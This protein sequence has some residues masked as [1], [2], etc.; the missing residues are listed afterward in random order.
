MKLND[1]MLWWETPDGESHE[2]IIDYV[3][4]L[5]SDQNYQHDLNLQNFRLYNDEEVTSLQL[6]GYAQPVNGFAGRHKVTL[7]VIKSMVD[8][9][10]SEITANQP[11]TT[12][13]TSGGDW[14]QQRKAQLL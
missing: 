7:N 3:D 8:A 5:V 4:R 2:V 1:E 11:T 9:A 13:L 12:F 14:A 6:S 10:T